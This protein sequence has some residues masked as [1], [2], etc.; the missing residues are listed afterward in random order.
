MI[1]HRAIAGQKIGAGIGLEEFH[2]Q[3]LCGRRLY[4]TAHRMLAHRIPSDLLEKG[5]EFGFVVIAH[6]FE[7][8][9]GLWHWQADRSFLIDDGVVAVAGENL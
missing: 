8:L 3:S 9:E 5:V 4:H 1:V 2:D 7:Q 6:V